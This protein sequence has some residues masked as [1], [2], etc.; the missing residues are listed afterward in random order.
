MMGTYVYG[1]KPFGEQLEEALQIYVR[2]GLKS[3]E[4]ERIIDEIIECFIN[5]K[6]RPSDYF[7][8][9]FDSVN[10]TDEIRKNFVTDLCKDTTLFEIEGKKHYLELSDKYSFYKKAKEFFRRQL[11]FV[12]STTQVEDIHLFTAQTKDLFVKPNSGSY[13]HGAFLAKV[14]NENDSIELYNSLK[15]KG[16]TWLLEERIIQDPEMA[17]WNASSVNT[18]RFTSILNKKGFHPLTPVLRC[19]R[20][21]SI[22]DNGGSG[23]ILANIDINTGVIYTDGLDENNVVYTH[24]PD[25]GIIFKGTTI[26]QWESLMK[27]VERLHRSVC[28]SHHYVGW[29]L[30]FSRGQWLVIEGNWGQFLNQYVDK[31]GRKDEFLKYMSEEPFLIELNV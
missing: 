17:Q 25:S 28:P 23:G 8:F 24:H 15:E 16:G 11:L 26:P 22:V 14:N 18:I 13:G 1:S 10:R 29:D 31:R 4:R 12:D 20:K 19:G 2:D 7:L 30:A 3:D 6:I 21:G 27:F 9:G 5:Y